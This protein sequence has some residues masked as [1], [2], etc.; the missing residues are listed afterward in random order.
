[1]TAVPRSPCWIGYF[2]KKEAYP[3]RDLYTPWDLAAEGQLYIG[4]T[5]VK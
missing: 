5:V 4:F 1:M 3:S 2:S